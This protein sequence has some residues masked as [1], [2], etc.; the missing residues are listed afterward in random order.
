MR[1]DRAVQLSGDGAALV[2]AVR[3][4]LRQYV[5]A[6]AVR[7]GAAV[8]AAHVRAARA[9]R[10]AAG[11]RQPRERRPRGRR[12]DLRPSGHPRA[13]R[14]SDRRRWRALVYQRATHAGKRVQALGG[15][16]NFIVVMPDADLDRGIPVIAESFYGCAGER[17]LAGSVLLPV[18]PAHGE[19]R[20]R[21]VESARA[22]KVGDGLEPGVTMGP[23]ISAAAPRAGARLRRPGRGGRRGARP[24]RPQDERAGPSDGFFVG[25]T[26]FD[27]VSPAMAIGQRGDLRTRG[28]GLPGEDSRRGVPRDG[29][30]SERQRDVDLHVERQGRARVRAPR[31]GVDGR[32]QHRRGGADGVLPVR[33]RARQLLR[34]PEGARPRRVRVLHGS[35]KSRFQPVVL[36]TDDDREEIVALS[37]ASTRSSSGPRR[38]RSIRSRSRARKA[39]TSGRRTASATSTSTAS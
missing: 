26:V 16:K 13:C 3:G 36:K 34:R 12:G 37:Q 5:R 28:D 18:G 6:Q 35:R 8:A 19:A 22:L 20:D 39:C 29:R 11:R 30:A 38:R 25:P 24:R 15:A 21:L 33:R 10:S 2:P 4:R 7:A 14:S 17:C 1:G 31:D 9:V 32:R 27:E 23:V